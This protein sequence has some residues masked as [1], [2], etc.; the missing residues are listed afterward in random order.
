MK[1]I[2]ISFRQLSVFDAVARTGSVSQA[3]IEISL[4]QS[5]TSLSLR[6]LEKSLGASLFERIGKKLVLNANGHRLRPQAHSLLQQG[7]DFYLDK[8]S[9]VLAGVIRLAASST[10]GQYLLP[11]ICS[12]FISRHPA[13]Q[14]DLS[15]ASTIEVIV[16]T[17]QMTVDLG[18]I[19]G[20]C[21]QRS[22]AS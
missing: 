8:G 17:E 13:V 7:Q 4:G 9:E 3:A 1:P 2:Q 21:H 12:G 5:A 14:V 16:K 19:E 15:I 18:L 20:P 22:L 11:Q 10:I 6:E